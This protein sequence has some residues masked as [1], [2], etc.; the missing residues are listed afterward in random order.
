[1]SFMNVL[2]ML[3]HNLVDQTVSTF[4]LNM[5]FNNWGSVTDFDVIFGNMEKLNPL[6]GIS[7]FYCKF[8]T[9]PINNAVAAA[10]ANDDDCQ[11]I[12]P[13]AQVN[14]LQANNVGKHIISH[15]HHLRA[16]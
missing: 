8:L 14:G 11:T 12:Y 15:S 3:L 2:C 7:S 5:M 16:T 10:A 4:L 1:M 6:I 13:N 9:P